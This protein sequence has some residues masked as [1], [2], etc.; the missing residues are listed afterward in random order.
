MIYKNVHAHSSKISFFFQWNT[1][2]SWKKNKE[3]FSLQLLLLLW[4]QNFPSSIHLLYQLNPVQ[5]HRAGVVSRLEVRSSLDRSPLYCRTTTET[6]NMHAVYNSP[7][8]P[9]CWFLDCRVEV[10]KSKLHTEKPDL[11]FKKAKIKVLLFVDFVLVY[12]F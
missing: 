2:G 11:N 9:K 10:N 4:R 1:S 5:G 6:N 12:I 8:C 3:S 7:V